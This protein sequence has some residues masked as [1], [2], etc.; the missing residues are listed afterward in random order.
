M[1]IRKPFKDDLLFLQKFL[2]I[3]SYYKGAIDGLFGPISSSALKSFNSDFEA[4]KNRFGAVDPRSERHLYTVHP[5]LQII[6]RTMINRSK[7]GKYDLKIISGTRSYKEQDDLYS[8]GRTT[9]GSIITNAKGG[10]SN[11]NFGLAFDIGLFDDRG[12]YLT[13]EGPYIEVREYSKDMDIE[14]GGDW[15]SFKDF[16]HYQLKTGKSISS[17]RRD[18]DLGLLIIPFS[19]IQQQQPQ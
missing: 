1:I 9:E 13:N 8:M 12:R 17:I 10:Q 6:A 11:H 19:G 18:F 16:P 15:K 2:K 7:S 3:T 5:N 14:W 4:I